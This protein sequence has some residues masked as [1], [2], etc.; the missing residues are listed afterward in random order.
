MFSMHGGM[1]LFDSYSEFANLP[2]KA[3]SYSNGK[4]PRKNA[5]ELLREFISCCSPVFVPALI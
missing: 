2:R 4:S 3:E 5:L 1:Q